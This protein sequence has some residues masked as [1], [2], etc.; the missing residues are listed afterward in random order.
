MEKCNGF[1]STSPPRTISL[2]LSVTASIA[3][4]YRQQLSSRIPYKNGVSVIDV[5]ATC[6]T[7]FHFCLRLRYK[8]I[9]DALEETAIIL[10]KTFVRADNVLHPGNEQTVC[11]RISF[12]RQ[13]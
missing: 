6:T 9:F 11:K 8:S 7:H 4:N 3:K 10:E 2:R 12:D 13:R 1:S 5:F